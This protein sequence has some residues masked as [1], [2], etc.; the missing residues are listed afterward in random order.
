MILQD[1]TER[2]FALLVWDAEGAPP[3]KDG[4]ITALW[5]SFGEDGAPGTWSLPRLVEEQADTLRA[6]FLAWIYEL[7]E[8]RIGDVRMVDH[9]ALRPGFSYWW[10]T[11]LAEKSYGKSSRL[12]DAVKLLALED[13]IGA[14]SAGRLILASGDKTLA[15]AIRL[16]C[17]NTGLTFE[18]R[19]LRAPT[20]GE[21]L[22]RRLYRS[23]PYMVRAGFSLVR[24][25][26]QRWPLRQKGRRSPQ[27]YRGEPTCIDYLIHLAP[28]AVSSGRYGSNYWTDLIGVLDADAVEVNWLHLYVAHQA[29]PSAAQARDLVARF[30]QNGA[31]VQFHACLDEVLGWSAI[32]GTLRDYGR[33]LKAGACLGR[34]RYHFRPAGSKIDLWPLFE[35]DWHNSLFGA[36]AI[37]NCLFLNILERTLQRMPHQKLG[38]YLQ[39]NQGWEM[40]FIHSWKAAGHGHLIGM[41]HSTVRYWDLRYFSDPRAYLRSGNSDLPLPD[42]VALN[43][44][45]SMAAYREGGYPE[46]QMTEVEALRYLYLADFSH[47]QISADQPPRPLRV[48]V[49]G[50]YLPSVTRRQMQ[51]LA[52]AAPDLPAE[53]RYTV[54]PHP[55]C[56]VQASHYP[57]LQLKITNAPLAELLAD[58][59]VAYTSNI[60]SAAVDAYSA[61]VPVVSA[62]EGEWFNMSPLRGLE[63]VTYV[64]SPCELAET[65]RRTR[66]G[67]RLKAEVYFCL[68]KQLPRWR[69][70]LGLSAP[71]PA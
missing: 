70:L 62:L 59:D 33:V 41:P 51:W 23:L 61:G 63:G 8:T 7:G 31:G 37:L 53:Y 55:N 1:T 60:T 58:C 21:A 36:T 65:L 50:D 64:T 12:A 15:H 10:M 27:H 43:G 2:R 17:L 11:L 34:A 6:R 45:V 19:R 38:V 20:E 5:R 69:R 35:Q 28:K 40:A 66:K 57:Q 30:N 18:W 68:D 3:P 54:K 14:H 25:L 44:P 16:L 9:L 13:L 52:D 47:A 49:L 22:V 48:L 26:K 29:V 46:D 56:P 24:Y 39:E 71:A 4:W 67:V 32:V 42:Q